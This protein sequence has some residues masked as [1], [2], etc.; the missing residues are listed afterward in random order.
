LIL[1]FQNGASVTAPERY[2]N[3]IYI[4]IL[5]NF[6]GHSYDNFEREDILIK[7]RKVLRNV[8]ILFFS[9]LIRFI[10]KLFHIIKS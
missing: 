7:L 5:R 9:F 1:I 6:I 4:K 8:I 3:E 2:F 10:S